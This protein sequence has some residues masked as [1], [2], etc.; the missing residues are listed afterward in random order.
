MGSEV[1]QIR[2]ATFEEFYGDMAQILLEMAD[3]CARS[4]FIISDDIPVTVEGKS[5]CISESMEIMS[6]FF[7]NFEKNL[8]QLN[9]FY[10]KCFEFLEYIA[11]ELLIS[12]GQRAMYLQKR[13]PSATGNSGGSG[14]G[15]GGGGM[16]CP[17][18]HKSVSASDSSCRHCGFSIK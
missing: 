8:K 12:D 9:S 17:A 2:E 16:T 3:I 1:I 6:T 13:F 7:Y 5:F 4:Q 15:G 10:S 14:G 11:S 18:C